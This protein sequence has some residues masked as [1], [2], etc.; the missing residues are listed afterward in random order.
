METAG[1]ARLGMTRGVRNE[2]R[3]TTMQFHRLAAQ[4]KPA[5]CYAPYPEH[6]QR[7]T[8]G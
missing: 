5:L 4:V 1:L 6:R 2:T 3:D 7:R 8:T